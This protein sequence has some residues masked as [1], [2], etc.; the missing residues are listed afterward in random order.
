MELTEAF[1]AGLSVNEVQIMDKI[2]T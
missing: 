1:I 2:A